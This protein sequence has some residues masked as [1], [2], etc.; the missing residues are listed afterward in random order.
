[1][2]A[3]LPLGA[4][5]LSRLE[6]LGFAS[7]VACFGLFA[8]HIRPYLSHVVPGIVLAAVLVA[9]LRLPFPAAVRSRLVP[10][11]LPFT[12]GLAL[13]W[14]AVHTDAVRA[15]AS[16]LAWDDYH[17]RICVLP[18]ALTTRVRA[19][20]GSRPVACVGLH[21]AY[22]LTGRNFTG[23]PVYAP[24]GIPSREAEDPW[25]F[26]LDARDRPDRALWLANLA[27]LGAS[28]FVVATE[29]SLDPPIERGWC[30]ADTARFRP[31]EREGNA[32]VYAIRSPGAR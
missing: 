31:I 12:L 18:G 13:A 14:V 16:E 19:A 17:T 25:R 1:V 7:V 5:G 9:A 2:L 28:Y 20:A 4:L 15:R 27:A 32:E 10:I 26:A 3:L 6:P 23:R 11:S 8:W 21:T 24:V 22:Q 30:A 29:D